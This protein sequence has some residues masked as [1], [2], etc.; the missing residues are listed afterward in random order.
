MM[1]KSIVFIAAF[2]LGL[3]ADCLCAQTPPPPLGI[4][5]TAEM[6]ALGREL[7]NDPILSAD[8]TVSCAKCHDAAKGFADGLPVAIGIR[9]R[10]GTMN[11]P[12][13]LNAAYFNE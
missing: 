4:S 9:G 6:I 2:A 1:R 5:P 11:A 13:I 3:L 7:F 8:G 10:A 12:T